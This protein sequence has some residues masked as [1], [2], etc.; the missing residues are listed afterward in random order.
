MKKN[1]VQIIQ[2]WSQSRM[3]K[4]IQTFLN[5]VNFYHWFIKNYSRIALF[6][7]IMSKWVNQWKSELNSA[8]FLKIAIT[9]Y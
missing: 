3:I 8:W 7:R 9:E 5:F 1:Q 4:E 6:V 2:D